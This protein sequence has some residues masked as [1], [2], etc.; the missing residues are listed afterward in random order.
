MLQTWLYFRSLNLNRRQT[1]A[2]VTQREGMS[3]LWC[4]FSD[5]FSNLQSYITG[6]VLIF[7]VS[8]HWQLLKE[9]ANFYQTSQNLMRGESWLAALLLLHSA[10]AIRP[11]PSFSHQ[12]ID[13][14]PAWKT[15]WN[16]RRKNSLTHE[17]K[18]QM[19]KNEEKDGISINQLV[20]QTFFRQIH[21]HTIKESTGPHISTDNRE[22]WFACY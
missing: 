5:K 8:T 16:P 20:N 10:Q 2:A 4:T 19:H 3:G 1:S 21:K 18:L 7:F 14:R 15:S 12:V 9:F 13:V 6:H 22:L 17:Y 11:F